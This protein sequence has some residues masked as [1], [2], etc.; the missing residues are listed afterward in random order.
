MKL[1]NKFIYSFQFIDHAMK[2][3]IIL[4]STTVTAHSNVVLNHNAMECTVQ[5]E[6]DV[7]EL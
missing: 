2:F 5:P 4:L 7:T 1:L 3:E 6:H